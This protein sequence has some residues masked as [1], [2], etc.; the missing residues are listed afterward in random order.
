MQPHLQ[1]S[2]RLALTRGSHQCGNYAVYWQE[3][4]RQSYWQPRTT[5]S[6]DSALRCWTSHLNLSEVLSKIWTIQEWI[7]VCCFS[8]NEPKLCLCHSRVER[9]FPQPYGACNLWLPCKRLSV[10]VTAFGVQCP[11]CVG[12]R[13]THGT[14]QVLGLQLQV[15]CVWNQSEPCILLNI[16][17]FFLTARAVPEKGSRVISE[18]CGGTLSNT[19][20]AVR[21]PQSHPPLHPSP[22]TYS[23]FVSL[24]IF[25]YKFTL[26]CILKCVCFKLY[27]TDLVRQS[28]VPGQA[29]ALPMGIG[30]GF[31]LA[32]LLIEALLILFW[33]KCLE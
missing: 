13:R 25:T 9:T 26:F 18:L 21:L 11:V 8:R 19:V 5:Q 22:L 31:T 10:R 32:G 6:Q 28:L 33:G 30:F 7:A 1:V 12:Q 15:Q 14:L 16:Y 3:V 17:Y 4:C 29:E 27:G 2:L 23:R 24:V 20:S